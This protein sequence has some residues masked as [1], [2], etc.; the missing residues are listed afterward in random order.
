ML[1]R[2]QRILLVVV[3]LALYSTAAIIMS[4]TYVS[5]GIPTDR[6]MSTTEMVSPAILA[7]G[8]VLRVEVARDEQK[9]AFFVTPVE[10]RIGI[11]IRPKEG[12]EQVSARRAIGEGMLL[13]LRYSRFILRGWGEIVV[14]KKKARLAPAPLAGRPASP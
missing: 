1:G 7:G 8:E 10:G 5:S 12:T 2:P 14:G 4:V 6:T 13:P 9:L 11:E 3:P